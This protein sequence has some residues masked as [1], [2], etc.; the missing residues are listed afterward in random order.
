LADPDF[1]D[2]AFLWSVLREVP[3]AANCSLCG[4]EDLVPYGIIGTPYRS[5]A[6]MPTS[7]LDCLVV[8]CNGCGLVRW[9]TI[10]AIRQIHEQG[11]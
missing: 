1:F 5:V 8:A 11:G 4:Q 2:P 7:D 9:H 6:G 3:S 10:S